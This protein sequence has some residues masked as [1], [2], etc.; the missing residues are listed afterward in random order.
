M[1]EEALAN[2]LDDALQREEHRKHHLKVR[3]C[4]LER[5]TS[6]AAPDGLETGAHGVAR[7]RL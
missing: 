7:E 1:E 3:Q 5:I 2:D 6:V 4:D